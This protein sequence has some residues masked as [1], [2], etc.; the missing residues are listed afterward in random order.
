MAGVTADTMVTG[1]AI[2]MNGTGIF[3]VIGSMISASTAGL[4]TLSANVSTTFNGVISDGTGSVAINQVNGTM[5]INGNNTF[6]GGVTFIRGTLSLGEAHALGS[7]T[8]TLAN[9][10]SITLTAT[11]GLSFS[12]N[13]TL[14]AASIGGGAGNITWTGNVTQTAGSTINRAGR[15]DIIGNVYLSANST[16]ANTLILG[17]TNNG[18]GSIS[19]NITN[20]NGAGGGTGTINKL[21]NGTWTFSGANTYNGTTQV[22][23]GTL[24]YGAN[25][26]IAA[27]SVL[28]IKTVGTSSTATIDLAGFNTTVNNNILF[29]G[30]AAAAGSANL[31]STGTGTLTI[32][33]STAVTY[34]N[35]TSSNPGT[36]TISGKVDLGTGTRTFSVADSTQTTNELAITAAISSSAGTYGVTKTGAGTMTFSGANTYTGVTSVQDG[37]LL[38]A[39]NIESR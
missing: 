31:L 13:M 33:G 35:A 27:T 11:N 4:K 2:T 32:A 34:S 17:G 1:M 23:G 6:S 21:G 20:W 29:G 8:L 10:A 37:I 24:I 39:P 26:T 30:T 36:A 3:P 15:T 28:N 5:A 22:Q 25:Q 19:G 18:D 7:G 14:A 16:G 9:T 12:N 38:R